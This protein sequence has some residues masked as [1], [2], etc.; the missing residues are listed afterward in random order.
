METETFV[1]EAKKLLIPILEE[2]RIEI[3]EDATL[4][5]QLIAQAEDEFNNYKTSFSCGSKSHDVDVLCILSANQSKVLKRIEERIREL[6]NETFNGLCRKCGKMIPWERLEA[7]PIT[8]QCCS[9]KKRN[10]GERGR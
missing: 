2:K 10:N 7:V 1:C 6:E 3:I 5:R 8:T 9:C 4:S